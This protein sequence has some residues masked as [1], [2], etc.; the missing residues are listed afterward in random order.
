LNVREII[1]FD[2]DFEVFRLD[3]GDSLENVVDSRHT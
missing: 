1:T 2:S 3:N